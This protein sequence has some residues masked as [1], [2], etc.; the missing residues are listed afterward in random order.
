MVLGTLESH[1]QKNQTE[2]LSYITHKNQLRMD[3]R[4]DYK[5]LNHKI[6]GRKHRDKLPDIGLGNDVLDLTPNTRPK[7]SRLYQT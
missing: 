3:S 1:I 4:L 6:P 7:N 5:T 2:P